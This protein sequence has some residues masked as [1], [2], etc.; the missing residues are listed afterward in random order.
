MEELLSEISSQLFGI[1]GM[2]VCLNITMI[3]IM[4]ALIFKDK[5]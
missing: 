3:A 2:L 4:F 5:R 1:K